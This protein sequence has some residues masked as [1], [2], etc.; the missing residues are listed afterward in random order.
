MHLEGSFLSAEFSSQGKPTESSTE[1]Q[2]QNYGEL[3]AK[4]YIP[5][6]EILEMDKEEED[7]EEDGKNV[8]LLVK[9]YEA[10]CELWEICCVVTLCK[11]L[12]SSSSAKGWES[13][14]V[15]EE[16]EDDDGEWVDVHHSSDEE[17][18]DM[19]RSWYKVIHGSVWT[20]CVCLC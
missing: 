19:V 1:A 8:I 14:S 2:I 16:E 3:G 4:D 6:A 15:S 5:G 10:V 17:Q 12:K 7:G 9:M 13:A 11:H 18:A 20:M